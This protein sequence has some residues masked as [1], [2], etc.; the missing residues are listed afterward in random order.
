MQQLRAGA[1]ITIRQLMT[2]R[3]SAASGGSAGQAGRRTGLARAVTEVLAPANLA[4]AQLLLVGWH[5]TPG[6]AGLGWGLLAATFCGLV[7]YGVVIAGVR[8]R[9]WTDRHLRARRQRPV[10]FLAGIASVLAGLAVLLALDVPRQLVA[11]VAAM[12]AGL[13]ATLLVTLW[14]KLSLHSAAASGTVA[15]LALVFGPALILAL[16]AIAL[17]AW[18][19]V[20][21]GDHTPAQTLAGAALGGLVAT[22][23]FIALR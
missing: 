4:V 22:T 17:V 10:P 18:S 15:I 6:P 21:L 13:A 5:G 8:R 1:V 23:V 2:T 16:P 12:L 20:R 11:L 14:W 19:R 7:P 9:R 3:P